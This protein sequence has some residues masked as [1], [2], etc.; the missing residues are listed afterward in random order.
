MTIGRPGGGHAHER[1]RPP[2]ARVG[3]GR[4]PIQDGRP[5]RGST[6]LPRTVTDPGRRLSAGRSGRPVDGAMI[7]RRVPPRHQ[8]SSRAVV[9]ARSRARRGPWLASTGPAGS[10]RTCG[11][12][13][14]R[15]VT[16]RGR[17]ERD[18]PSTSAIA[19]VDHERSSAGVS[20][21]P[22][23]RR[24]ERHGRRAPSGA[25]T[26][27]RSATTRTAAAATSRIAARPRPEH[28]AV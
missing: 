12:P 23:D 25:P 5:C 13:A 28:A 11:P 7:G 4:D 15:P 2:S 1:Q 17:R 9:D 20:M 16:G 3:R 18:R 27:T 21:D 19:T 6:S 22:A 26:S 24:R 10:P 8:G 14:A